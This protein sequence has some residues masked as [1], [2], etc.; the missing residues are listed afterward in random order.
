MKFY[1]LVFLAFTFNLFSQNYYTVISP[2][3]ESELNDVFLVNQDVGWIVGNKGIILYTSDGG[4]NWVRKSTL[5]N[6]DLL[7]VFFL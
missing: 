6:Y 2:F 5:F 7:K 4:Q 3:V 1:L